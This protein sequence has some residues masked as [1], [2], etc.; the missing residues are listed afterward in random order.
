MLDEERQFVPKNANAAIDLNG[1][2]AQSADIFELAA[3]AISRWQVDQI[4]VPGIVEVNLSPN[5]ALWA[6]GRC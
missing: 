5:A 3:D 2:S 1:R 6:E 4:S